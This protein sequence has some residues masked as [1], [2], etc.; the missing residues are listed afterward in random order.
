MSESKTIAQLYEE[1]MA[2]A[3]LKKEFLMAEK[4][5]NIGE[6]SAA[7]GCQATDE[8]IQ[9]FLREMLSKPIKLTM[10]ELDQVAG[11]TGEKTPPEPVDITLGTNNPL[12]GS[13]M[14]IG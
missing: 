6:F 11:G 8:E 2:S 9:A 5:G 12:P 3:A 4:S 7:H 13:T 1:V 10:D 14:E